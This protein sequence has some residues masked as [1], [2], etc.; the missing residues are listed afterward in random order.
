M[1]GAAANAQFVD[2]TDGKLRDAWL[3]QCQKHIGHCAEQI[4]FAAAVHAHDKA[5]GALPLQGRTAGEAH[6]YVF[7]GRIVAQ[8]EVAQ[9]HESSSG[10][11]LVPKPKFWI[12]FNGS[13]VAVRKPLPHMAHSQALQPLVGALSQARPW[14][15]THSDPLAKPHPIKNTRQFFCIIRP[16]KD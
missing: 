7:D 2:Q 1:A 12:R 14:L 10:F 16:V 4:G 15:I 3:G 9:P 13:Q 6:G 5:D 11:S 8:M